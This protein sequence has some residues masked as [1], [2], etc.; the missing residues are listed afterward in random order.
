[1]DPKKAQETVAESGSRE[2][3][4]TKKVLSLIEKLSAL[5]GER[6]NDW[7][8]LNEMTAL[9]E[10][11]KEDFERSFPNVSMELQNTYDDM[12]EAIKR[13]IQNDF[14]YEWEIMA[15]HFE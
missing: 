12:A 9:A 10:R 11:I 6:T 14:V 13:K 15:T 1:M 7:V 3:T 5:R 4:L 2:N 8:D